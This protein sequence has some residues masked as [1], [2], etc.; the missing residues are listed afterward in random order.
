MSL[1]NNKKENGGYIAL[2][3]AIIM[4][5]IL[6][7]ISIVTSQ[8]SFL[9]RFDSQVLEL[10]DKSYNLANGCLNHA[11]LKLAQGSY[12]GNETVTIGTDSCT[13]D[14]I[15]TILGNTVITSKATVGN[16]TTKLKLTVDSLTLGIVSLEEI[17]GL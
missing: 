8:S 13:I 14:P 3:S 17:S 10:K 12:G 11:R 16:T 9:G 5:V 1:L 7:L 2:I 6:I 15:S 4:T